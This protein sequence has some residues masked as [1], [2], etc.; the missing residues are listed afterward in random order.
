MTEQQK[1]VIRENPHLQSGKLASF[2]GVNAKKVDYFK[3]RNNFNVWTYSGL[4]I[5]FHYFDG[6]S[7]DYKIEYKGKKVFGGC[8]KRAMNVLD[9]LIWCIEN[10]M[11]KQPRI[12][13][14][15]FENLTLE[16]N[17]EF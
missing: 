6:W 16:S 11:F 9:H 4:G 7:V 2:L 17:N 12:E 13:H 1:R 10:G 15:Y 3:R 5:P 8:F 14:P